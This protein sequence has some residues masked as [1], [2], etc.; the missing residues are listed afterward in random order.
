MYHPWIFFS[1]ASLTRSLGANLNVANFC[2]I[3]SFAFFS[4]IL[5]GVMNSGLYSPFILEST[6]ILESHAGH[7]SAEVNFPSSIS[8]PQL[9]QRR[10]PA[11]EYPSSW[12]VSSVA[13]SPSF[14][15][16][17]VLTSSDSV[18]SQNGH[19]IFPIEGSN[20]ISPPQFLHL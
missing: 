6:M 14:I 7:L 4:S 8:H 5:K 11:A 18:E 15:S 17:P 9:G 13:T 2:F 10:L 19:F 12:A 1:L 20:S 3:I 16:E